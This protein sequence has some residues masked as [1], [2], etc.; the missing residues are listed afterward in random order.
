MTM[1]DAVDI[2]R[3]A[4]LPESDLEREK[5]ISMASAVL[6]SSRN[7]VM[8]KRAMTRIEAAIAARTPAVLVAIAQAK[9][10]GT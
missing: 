3:A 7:S 4:G 10:R 6:M 2:V 8:R 9:R 5:E 1:R